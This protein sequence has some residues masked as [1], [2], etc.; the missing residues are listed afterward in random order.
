MPCGHSRL[1]VEMGVYR[2]PYE[3][4]GRLS[5]EM[6]RACRLVVDPGMHAMGWTR[7]QAVAFLRD[8]TA[9]PQH[10]IDYEIDRYIGWPAQALGYKIGEIKIRELRARAEAALGA[11]FD[12][13][14][15]H[16]AILLQGP[17]PLDV[18]EG[19]IDRWIQARQ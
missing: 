3:D 9:L 5:L 14:D 1:A 11:K 8:N 19:E 7:E 13:R 18:L 15:F 6:W 12:L 16:D 17:M 10:S 2:T 4:F